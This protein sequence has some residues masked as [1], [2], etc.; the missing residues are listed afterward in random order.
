[1]KIFK[2][3]QQF[4]QWW[5]IVLMIFVLLTSFYSIFQEYQNL[6][7]SDGG[8]IIALIITIIIILIVNII[9]FSLKLKTRI[10]EKGITY[11]FF[12][13]HL[14]SKIIAWSDLNKC[15]VRKYSP[16]KE[17]GGWGLRGG[18]RKSNKLG[19]RTSGRAYNVKGNNGIQLEF[20]DGR[21]LLFGTQELEKAKQVLKTYSNKL[22]SNSD[23]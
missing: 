2:E 23:V 15:Y 21:K 18:W 5:L 4:N 22:N 19:I 16:I 11:Q 1:M 9:I 7:K 6:D 14:K 3:T 10:D 8:R 20:K 12:P 17:Y 13:I